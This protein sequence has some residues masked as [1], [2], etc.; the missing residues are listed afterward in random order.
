ELLRF[1]DNISN[2]NIRIAIDYVKQ[3]F[4]SG[5]VDTKKILEIY[6]E[7]RSYIIPLHEFIRAIMRGNAVHYNPSTSSISNLFDV[8]QNDNAEHFL[9][10]TLLS[11]LQSNAIGGTNDGFLTI[12]QVYTELQGIGYNIVQIDDVITKCFNNKLIESSRRGDLIEESNFPSMIRI[13]T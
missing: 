2:G 10:P 7:Q 11:L 12:K 6:R 1:L 5:H 3:F 4:G 8:T 9:L 13:T